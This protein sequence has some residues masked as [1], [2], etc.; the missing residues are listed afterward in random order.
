MKIT[1]SRLKQIIKE[2]LDPW[3]D[4]VDDPYQGPR[5]PDTWHE[6]VNQMYGFEQINPQDKST[7]WYDDMKRDLSQFT[8]VISGLES[9]TIAPDKAALN[10]DFT[11]AFE[12]WADRYSEYWNES[13]PWH[14]FT[15][16]IEGTP[17]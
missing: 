12:D 11:D 17:V 8:D 16:L 15:W 1:K 2:E 6:T 3:F 5:E 9:G 13:E 14:L 10:K 7:T 4:S